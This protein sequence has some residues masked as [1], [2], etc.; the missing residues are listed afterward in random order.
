M[1]NGDGTPRS[2][3]GQLIENCL[4][5][6]NGDH[7]HPGYNHNL[8]LGGTDVTMRG[9]EVHSSLTGHNYK[10]RAHRNVVVGC[11]IH[12]SLNREFDL[13][14][15]KGDT[16]R[17][18]SDTILAG[19]V[20][21]KDPNCRGNKAVIHFGQDGGKGHDGTLHLVHNTIVTPFISP[22]VDLSAPKARA[23]LLN[24]IVWNGGGE[25][26]RAGA[27]FGEGEGGGRI[28]GI[29]REQLACGGFPGEGGEVADR[30]TQL[31]QA[32]W[33][34]AVCGCRCG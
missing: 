23:N 10:S 14:D 19:N 26:G 22:V 3:T 31:R 29:G 18:G 5:H 32:G 6:S 12:D 34:A 9:C 17:P 28:A 1:S 33:K 11:Y 27:G 2:A 8:Y 21:V 30:G 25:T 4:I 16:D 20:I 15:A 7:A 13:V 24:N